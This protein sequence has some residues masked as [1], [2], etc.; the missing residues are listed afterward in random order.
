MS[1]DLSMNIWTQGKRELLQKSMLI[2]I[3]VIFLTYGLILTQL[4]EIKA[5]KCKLE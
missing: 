4:R 2:E 3:L 1:I 5:I